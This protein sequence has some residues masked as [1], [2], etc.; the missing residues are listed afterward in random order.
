MDT[1]PLS[2]YLLCKYFLPF[3]DLF[4][5][6][7]NCVFHRAEVFPVNTIQLSSIF[8]FMD[9]AFGV[10]S[11]VSSPNPRGSRF[12]GRFIGLCSTFRSMIPF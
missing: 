11:E 9:S 7:L 12:S 5:H 2:N 10:A 8:S 4:F 3:C 6:F 1:N